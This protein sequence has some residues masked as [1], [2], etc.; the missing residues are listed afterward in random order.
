MIFINCH[1]ATLKHSL[2]LFTDKS[3]SGRDFWSETRV[4]LSLHQW[5]LGFS[6]GSKKMY[7]VLFY[8]TTSTCNYGSLPC[9][10]PIAQSLSFF[11]F[12]RCS[13][14]I[15]NCHNG[16]WRL[17]DR[18]DTCLATTGAHNTQEDKSHVD[19]GQSM[20]VP[21]YRPP[22]ISL[23]RSRITV[24]SQYIRTHSISTAA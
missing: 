10:P 13:T 20:L 22:D 17:T 6:K 21:I 11:L 9:F 2:E 1:F 23:W 15:T 7:A 8:L 24:N 4:I 12:C 18:S 3:I 16:L 5:H 14:S 19:R